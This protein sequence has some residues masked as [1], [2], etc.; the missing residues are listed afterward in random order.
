MDCKVWHWF[1]RGTTDPRESFLV[2]SRMSL[3]CEERAL[4]D[5]ELVLFFEGWN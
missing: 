3:A 2:C 4:T 1:E 5:Y